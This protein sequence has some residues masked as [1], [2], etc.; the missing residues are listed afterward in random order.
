MPKLKNYFIE[1][2]AGLQQQSG[3]KLLKGMMI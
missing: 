1:Q 2:A 3:P